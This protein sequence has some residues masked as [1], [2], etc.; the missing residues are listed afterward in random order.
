MDHVKHRRRGVGVAV[1]SFGL[2]IA[3][4]AAVAQ[5]APARPAPPLPAPTGAVVNVSTEAQLQA[6][7][8]NLR[9]GTT[10]VLAPGLYALTR[11]LY[12]KGN[13]VDVGIRGATS[14]SDDVV[15]RGPGM[16]QSNHGGVPFGVWTGDGVD[17]IT[18]ANLTIRDLYFHPIIFNA[19]T[20]RPHVYNVHLIE[21]GE[22]FIK[23]N[24]DSSGGGVD[25][26]VVEYSILEYTT[27]ARN[28]YTNG[29]D[30]H[31]GD[32]WI[33]RHNLFRNLVPPNN[34]G[35]AGP[36]VLMWNHSTN[37]LTEGNTFVN[38]SRGISYGLI[39]RAGHD[40]TGDVIRNNIFY[41]AA[42]QPGDVGI[43]VA[44]SPGT[45]VLNNT[46]VMSGTYPFAIEYR[47]V[48]S[49]GT[50]L[51]NNLHD[52]VILAREG[53]TGSEQHNVGTANA[54][55]FVDLSNADL[56]LAASAGAAIDQ[57]M[58]LAGVLTDWDGELRPSGSGYDVG[59]DEFGAGTTAYGIGGHITDLAGGRGMGGVTVMLGGARQDQAVTDENGAYA[60]VG[61]PAN[62]SYLLIPSLA[63][64]RFL[65]LSR[66]FLDLSA[67]EADAD[68]SGRPANEPPRVTLDVPGGRSSVNGAQVVLE[69]QAS[70]ADGQVVSVHF[71]AGSTRLGVDADVPYRL[72]WRTSVGGTYEMTAVAT[73]DGGARAT[74]AVVLLN[75][76][77]KR[78]RQ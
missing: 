11:T 16:R 43:H 8:A 9:S 31:T 55:M 27:T 36:A 75:V 62:V 20:S 60:F 54:S 70:D 41:R 61:L 18:I 73:D 50:V 6:A 59:A 24:P 53:A 4:F 23:S 29:V 44:D 32:N 48:G 1:A 64:Y 25:D 39:E 3:A 56:H 68:F 72:H 66:S 35:L 42:S 57:G 14:N 7:M 69:A 46:V 21:A 67:T 65:P 5:A 30:V 78:G 12:F 47:Y 45:E 58:L 13:L 34:N 37:T 40:H 17:G 76:R 33:I 26:G 49:S 74:S 15:L 38:C 28:S 22:Q 52:G 51:T 77:A 19:G 2:A 63:D 10:I 71:Y